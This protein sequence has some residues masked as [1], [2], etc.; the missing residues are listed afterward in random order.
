MG[1]NAK[2]EENTEAG[3][4]VAAAKLRR[5]AEGNDMAVEAGEVVQQLEL[6]GAFRRYEHLQKKDKFYKDKHMRALKVC[7][8]DSQT[9]VLGD[10]AANVASLATR[11][12]RCSGARTKKTATASLRRLHHGVAP[13]GLAVAAA[14]LPGIVHV[15]PV[16]G[17]RPLGRRAALVGSAALATVALV[18]SPPLQR[19]ARCL[20]QPLRPLPRHRCLC[21]RLVAT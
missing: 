19:V 8:E 9:P 14:L 12:G 18:Q 16:V 7:C 3:V 4:D 1:D 20:P 10:W 5:F 21:P 6:E 2:V 15:C 11:R 17:L 13:T